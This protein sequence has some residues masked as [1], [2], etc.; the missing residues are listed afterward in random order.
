MTA[1]DGDDWRDLYVEELCVTS[2][3]HRMNLGLID[4]SS[5]ANGTGLFG[6]GRP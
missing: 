2:C 5:L 1:T 4:M 6:W 3:A